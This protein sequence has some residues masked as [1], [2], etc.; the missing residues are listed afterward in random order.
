MACKWILLIP[1]SCNPVMQAGQSGSIYNQATALQQQQHSLP[2]QYSS[3][4]QFQQPQ[5]NIPSIQRSSVPRAY[6][7]TQLPGRVVKNPLR[8]K[9]KDF[10]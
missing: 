3:F 1:P 5:F 7:L 8:Q 10:I 4:Q 9:M 2:Q 6:P